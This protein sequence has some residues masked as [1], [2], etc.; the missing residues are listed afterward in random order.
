MGFI[1]KLGLLV[2]GAGIFLAGYNCDRSQNV[3][4]KKD[5]LGSIQSVTLK[6]VGIE[7]T[8]VQDQKDLNK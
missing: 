6:Q 5:W 1:K 4:I 3:V 2:A 8:L 7:R